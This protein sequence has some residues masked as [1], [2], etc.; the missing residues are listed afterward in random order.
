MKVTGLILV[1]ALM[2]LAYINMRNREGRAQ[3]EMNRYSYPQEQTFG[4]EDGQIKSVGC[5][6]AQDHHLQSSNTWPAAE[7]HHLN[8][9]QCRFSGVHLVFTAH[10]CFCLVRIKCRCSHDHYAYMG[11]LRCAKLR[12]N[13]EPTPCGSCLRHW[14]RKPQ[15]WHGGWPRHSASG[16]AVLLF[17][18]E[19]GSHAWYEAGLAPQSQPWSTLSYRCS[20]HMRRCLQGLGQRLTCLSCATSA[21]ATG[22]L[23]SKCPAPLLLQP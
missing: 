14:V 10:L 18:G 9:C 5:R 21:W 13:R 16:E 6:K 7:I 17:Q 3:P 20:L 2:S 19:G 23:N 22:R 12:V 1:A 11:L 15:L 4:Q 8:S